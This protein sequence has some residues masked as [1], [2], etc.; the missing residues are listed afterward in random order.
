[1]VNLDRYSINKANNTFIKENQK[2]YKTVRNKDEKKIMILNN[3][4]NII[5]Q[6]FLYIQYILLLSKYFKL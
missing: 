3:I 6:L 2:V 1:M 5:E 4:K